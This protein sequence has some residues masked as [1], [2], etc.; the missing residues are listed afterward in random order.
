MAP[1]GE[2][3]QTR[4]IYGQNL[5]RGDCRVSFPM[6]SRALTPRGQVLLLAIDLG[7]RRS[8]EI[9]GGSLLDAETHMSH[10]HGTAVTAT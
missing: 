2:L 8:Q 1:V 7:C 5:T 4:L 9:D 6:I 10:V 3:S